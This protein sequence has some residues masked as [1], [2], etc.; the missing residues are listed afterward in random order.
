MF[1]GP[2]SAVS[3]TGWTGEDALTVIEPIPEAV[4]PMLHQILC[5]TKIEP[6]VNCWER[7]SLDMKLTI[8]CRI[9]GLTFMYDAFESC[10]TT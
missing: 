5:R 4:E 2:T 1:L 8:V 3:H 10:R 7:F 9:L 6:W